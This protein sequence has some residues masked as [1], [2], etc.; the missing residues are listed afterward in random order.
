ML[1]PASMTDTAP[2]TLAIAI[3][4]SLTGCAPPDED[5]PLENTASADVVTS[6]V[7][8]LKLAPGR[9][10]VVRPTDATTWR[11]KS[12]PCTG[13]SE[14]CLDY[15]K[16]GGLTPMFDA[17][18]ALGV[19]AEA[20][21]ERTGALAGYMPIFEALRPTSKTTT[22]FELVKDGDEVVVCAA[23]TTAYGGCAAGIRVGS[24]TDSIDRLTFSLPPEL[25]RWMMRAA[26]P[27]YREM[28]YR[29]D[30]YE[31]S[32]SGGIAGSD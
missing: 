25:E 6:G 15:F 5:E 23:G 2:R 10:V 8:T 4:L 11:A 28:A 12:R 14:T 9:K 26:P 31:V 7:A 22:K 30:T 16:M 3:A 32:G 18:A 20:Y 21:P 19:L 17:Q 29:F 27:E 24:E 13:G 1:R